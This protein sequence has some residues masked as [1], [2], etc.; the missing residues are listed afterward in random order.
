MVEVEVGLMTT[1]TQIPWWNPEAHCPA[2]CLSPSP[3]TL[4]HVLAQHRVAGLWPWNKDSVNRKQ[5]WWTFCSHHVQVHATSKLLATFVASCFWDKTAHYRV[6]LLRPV[7]STAVHQ[8]WCLISILI[9]N[10]CLVNGL[11]WQRRRANS[12]SLTS[13]TSNSESQNRSLMFIF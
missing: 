4:P 13:F 9:C 2:I 1:Y 6:P 11:S 8:S 12:S 3:P 10:T 7:Q 5:L